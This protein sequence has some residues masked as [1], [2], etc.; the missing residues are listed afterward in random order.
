MRF[1]RGPAK[2]GRRLLLA[3]PPLVFLGIFYFYPLLRIFGV[4]LAG[5]DGALL[6]PLKRLFSQRIYLGILGFTCWQ[7]LLSTALTLAAALPAAYV[8]ARFRF[9][10]KKLLLGLTTIPFVLPTVVVAAAFDALLGPH[11]VVN[12]ALMALFGLAKAPFDLQHSLTMI[13]LAHLFYNFTVGLRIIG[14]YW[15]QL[16]RNLE[17]SA[18][19]LG[20]SPWQVFRRITLPLLRPAIWSAALLIFIF[21]FS[22]FGVILILGGPRMAT[23]EVEIYRQTLHLFN[24]P[25][26]AVLALVQIGFTFAIMGAYTRLQRRSTIAVTPSLAGTDAHPPEGWGERLLVGS[27][28]AAMALYLGAPLAALLL[29]SLTTAQGLALTYYRQL[30][31]NPAQSFIF[32]P[33]IQ[34]IGNSLLFAGLALTQA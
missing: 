13:L 29:R 17:A 3:L 26:A 6:A 7:A 1:A 22:S 31:H 28:L 14:G 8:F 24:L 30:F 16:P 9:P 11:G 12:G 21:C 23:L 27:V 15:A 2:P 34:A 25:M 19:M 5:P 10:A 32:V 18:C 20:A 4:S 33:P